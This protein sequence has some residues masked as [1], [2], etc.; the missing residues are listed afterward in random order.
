MMKYDQ[1]E[2]LQKLPPYLFVRLEKLTSK[3][4]EEGVNIIDFGIGDPDLPTPEPIVKAIQD[5][6]PVNKNQKYSSSQ[7][8]RTYE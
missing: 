3:K 8:K 5:A 4:R 7:G 2:R 6:M 1:S